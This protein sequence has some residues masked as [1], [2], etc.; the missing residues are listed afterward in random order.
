MAAPADPEGR[1]SDGGDLLVCET[2]KLSL[3]PEKRDGLG[4][5]TNRRT[6]VDKHT[7]E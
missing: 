4:C 2:D 6:R 1:G 3:P 7:C 5:K